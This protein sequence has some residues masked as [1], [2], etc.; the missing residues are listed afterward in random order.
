MLFCLVAVPLLTG[1]RGGAAAVHAQ[2]LEYKMEA[3]VMGGLGFYLGDANKTGLY[4]NSRF[5]GALMA[6]YNL[7]PRMA[8]KF[9]LGYGTLAGNAADSGEK[10]PDEELMRHKF[11]NPLADLGC[12]FELN[13]WGFG[14][15]TGYKGTKRITPYIQAGLGFTLCNGVFTPNIPIGVGVK[16]KVTRRLNVGL[17]WTMRFSMSDKLDGISD[18]FGIKSGFLKNKDSYGWTMFYVSYDF[19]PRLR[20][21][22]N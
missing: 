22:N 8:L 6:R 11:S 19:M 14:T 16:Y 3:G 10:Y 15:G 5:A 20:K 9:N 7:N 1:G 2:E 17:D 4:A 13:F 18:P 21:C 12:Q